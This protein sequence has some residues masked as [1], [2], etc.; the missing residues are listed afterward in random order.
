MK[1]I[2]VLSLIIGV[3]CLFSAVTGIQKWS[4]SS[5]QLHS[6]STRILTLAVG[7]IFVLWHIGIKRNN[8][9]GLWLTRIIFFGTILNIMWQAVAVAIESKSNLERGWILVSQA[10]LAGLVYFWLRYITKIWNR[11]G[12]V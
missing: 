9:W 3:A 6:I 10:V 1:V 11:R 12:R 5:I 4:N 2:R 8:M 7:V